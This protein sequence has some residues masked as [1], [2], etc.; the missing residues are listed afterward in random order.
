M[1]QKLLPVYSS[2]NL[3]QNIKVM[4]ACYQTELLKFEF[5]NRN[6]NA[7]EN[8]KELYR[9]SQSEMP[10]LKLG[11]GTMMNVDDAKKF[12]DAG[13]EFL[14]SP[15]I[16]QELLD[17]TKRN[18]IEWI[19]NCVTGSE[20]GLALNNGIKFVKLFP[21]TSLGGP[22]FVKN[23]RGPFYM[24]KFQV[25]GGIKGEIEEVKTY[26]DAGASMVALGNSF[27]DNDLSEKDIIDKIINLKRGIE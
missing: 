8:F 12:I 23:I 13:A 5:T 17:Y 20:I 24:M 25:S 2:P 1:A 19:P 15:L 9:L 11:A 18:K 7:L 22:Q 4:R 27:F 16:S 10:G 26:L 14:I 21:I 6:E 3:N